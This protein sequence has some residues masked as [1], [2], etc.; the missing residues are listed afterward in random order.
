MIVF[1]ESEKSSTNCVSTCDSKQK[2]RIL[3]CRLHVLFYFCAC[4]ADLNFNIICF[5]CLDRFSHDWRPSVRVFL[6][7]LSLLF[8]CVCLMYNDVATRLGQFGRENMKS[9][10]IFHRVSWI[11][12]FHTKK[13]TIFFLDSPQT[14]KYHLSKWPS[15]WRISSS[16]LLTF[17]IWFF[18][19]DLDQLLFDSLRLSTFVLQLYLRVFTWPK[20]TDVWRMYFRIA[21]TLRPSH[22]SS[23][24]GHVQ[25]DLFQTTSSSAI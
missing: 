20:T 7:I 4:L 3:I 16:T 24:C 9:K 15:V 13:Y 12:P 21:W 8:P 1:I 25:R 18:L 14:Y 6:I 19:I 17:P 11:C 10:N 22:Y 23:F 5:W 2:L